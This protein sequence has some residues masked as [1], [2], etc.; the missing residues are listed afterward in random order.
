MS[1]SQ[2]RDYLQR[3]RALDPAQSF[4]CEAPAGSGKTELLTQRVLTLLARVDQPEAVLAIT[5]T[6]KAAAEMRERILHALNAGQELKPAEPHAQTTWRLARAVLQRDDAKGWHILQNPNRLQIRTFDSLCAM[7]TQALPLH[8]SLGVNVSISDDAE[9]LYREAVGQLLQTLEQSVP[10]ADALAALLVHLDN[11]FSKVEE[12]LVKMLSSRDAWMPL[13]N[14]ELSID[15]VRRVLEQHLQHVVDDKVSRVQQMVPPA[16]QRAL[17]GLAG[18][19]AANAQRYC[20]DSPLTALQGIDLANEWPDSTEEGRVQW[21]ALA[22]W[23]LTQKQEWRKRLDKNC[24]FP[25]GEDKQEKAAFKQQKQAMQDLVAQLSEVPD[26]LCALQ[27]ISYWPAVSYRGAQW[28]VLQALTS[29]LPVLVAHL[30]LVFRSRGEIDFLEMSLRANMALG[31]ESAPTDLALRLDYKIQHILVDE[32]QDTSFSQVQLIQKLTAGW[33]PD[34]GRTLFCVGDAMQSIYGFRGANVGLF[35]HCR[36]HGLGSVPL[37]PLRLTTNFRSQAGVVHWINRTFAGAFPAE[38]DISAGAVG[39]SAADA[40]RAEL[41][42][43][44]V[45][46]HVYEPEQEGLLGRI[47][48]ELIEQSKAQTPNG[49]I[50]ILARNRNHVAAIIPALKQAGLRFRA[51]DLEPLA[52]QEAIVDLMALTRALLDPA[53]RVAWLS[54]LRAPWCGLTLADLE[55]IAAQAGGGD[56]ALVYVQIDCA[57]SLQTERKPQVDLFA[58]DTHD[59]QLSVQGLSRL[60]R[61]HRVLVQSLQQRERAPLRQW[62][63]GTWIALGGAAC[64]QHSA[65]MDNVERYFQ[66]LEA[67][68]ADNTQPSVLQLQAQLERL[69]AA[70]DPTADDSLQVMTIHKSKGLEFDTVILPGLHRQ[71]RSSD[72]ELLLWQ[73]RLSLHG[74]DEWLLAPI[75]PV[76]EDKDPIYKHLEYEKKKRERFEACRLLYVAC[77]RAK[78]RLHLLAEVKSSAEGDEGRFKAPASGS[79]LSYI[80]PAVAMTAKLHQVDAQQSDVQSSEDTGNRPLKRLPAS[81]VLPSL[82]EGN[83]LA[84]FVA[85]YQFDNQIVDTSWQRHQSSVLPRHTGT[86]VHQILQ[87]IGEQ[88]IDAWRVRDLQECV[89]PWQSRLVAMGLTPAQAAQQVPFVLRCVQQALSNKHFLWMLSG[90]CEFEY[91]VSCRKGNGVQN[92]IIDVLRT[93]QQRAWVVDYKTSIPEEG[94]NMEDFLGEQIQQY[95]DTIAHYCS[96][97]AQLGFADV[98]GA[99]F[100]PLLGHWQVV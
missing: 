54:V 52:E 89:L 59:E 40:F 37:T 9:S 90:S 39:F 83:L 30:Q 29:V 25:P 63:E 47:T 34:D 84:D 26:L 100:F 13:L 98:Q 38:H 73:E 61:V 50:A 23:L 20:A 28:Q 58:T 8:S 31:D 16:L 69:Y 70:P 46:T 85:P 60:R 17:F 11:Q 79:L 48:V 88:G 22:Q 91:A 92:I 72:Q 62:V 76:G 33:Q 32:F 3:Q 12:L 95:R 86:L 2:P 41:P 97:V 57:L 64:L 93:E 6:R 68:T 55:W 18:F 82:P 7:L 45:E 21:Q 44:A 56:G 14:A 67:L 80:W 19:A 78:K 74:A 15:D 99:L 43:A 49:K 5:F 10:W 27:D 53:D 65:D 77:T 96:V 75:S 1:N 81:W 24:G 4:I 35:L 66:L 87:T 42:E 94:Q 51:V 71:P 36:A